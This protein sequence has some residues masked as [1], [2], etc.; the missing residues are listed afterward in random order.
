MR[1]GRQNWVLI[2]Y[3][4]LLGSIHFY[5]RRFAVLKW[6]EDAS[7]RVALA[8][9]GLNWYVDI[10]QCSAYFKFIPSTHTQTY[11]L[12]TRTNGAKSGHYPPP[13]TP[14]TPPPPLKMHLFIKKKSELFFT[15]L[16]IPLPDVCVCVCVGGVC[17]A[18]APTLC[19]RWSL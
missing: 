7:V 11:H 9:D 8:W 6:S 10:C 19:G 2:P 15:A 13:A 4:S 12:R 1:T 17:L 3:H 14:P 16:P 18:C 5:P